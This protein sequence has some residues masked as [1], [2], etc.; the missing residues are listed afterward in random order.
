MKKINIIISLIL[1]ALAFSS[2]ES[3]KDVF[4]QSSEHVLSCPVSVDG[5]NYTTEL[6]TATTN[7]SEKTVKFRLFHTYDAKLSSANVEY[8][9]YTSKLPSEFRGYSDVFNSGSKDDINILINEKDSTVC[10]KSLRDKQADAEL[11]GKSWKVYL[12]KL[13]A[14]DI[15]GST[16]ETTV[17]LHS[18][19]YVG[20][21][22]VVY[23]HTVDPV[24]PL[25]FTIYVKAEKSICDYTA[26][27]YEYLFDGE[28]K[29]NQ[30]GW[31]NDDKASYNA[32]PGQAAKGGYYIISTPV[33][34][35]N[36]EF[37]T[38]G[39]HRLAIR[40][41]AESGIWGK[42]TQYKVNTKDGS[43]EEVTN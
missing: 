4:R 7:G 34:R 9:A 38:E 42:W 36:H 15:Y 3:R 17:W 25:D 5:E 39:E 19:N 40:C 26:V 16:S 8:A 31:E 32:N 12:I 22:A 30:S 21:K 28:I 13:V 35:V 27:A 37:Q 11:Q 10:F 6:V 18:F 20:M 33:T 14:T 41:K 24:D 1:M 2:C 29:Y 23:Q 43:I